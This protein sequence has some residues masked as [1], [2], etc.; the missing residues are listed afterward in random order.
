MYDTYT[1]C[2]FFHVSFPFLPSNVESLLPPPES[3]CCDFLWPIECCRMDR[4]RSKPSL[5]T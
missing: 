3:G 1:K 5:P 4:A 2:R